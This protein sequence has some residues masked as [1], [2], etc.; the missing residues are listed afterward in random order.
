MPSPDEQLEAHLARERRERSLDPPDARPVHALSAQR[1]R[2]RSFLDEDRA[3]LA[4][5]SRK[6]CAGELWRSEMT[7]TYLEEGYSWR[8]HD[9]D[10][11]MPDGIACFDTNLI[12]TGDVDCE[13]YLDDESVLIVMGSLRCA[14]MYSVGGLCV[15][16]DVIVRGTMLHYYN[17]WAFECLGKVSA[18]AFVSEDKMTTFSR[19]RSVIEYYTHDHSLGDNAPD[20]MSWL[21]LDPEEGADEHVQALRNAYANGRD[22]LPPPAVPNRGDEAHH[23]DER[24]RARRASRLRSSD[25]EAFAKLS[26]DPVARVRAECALNA[27]CPELHWPS[28][29]RDPDPRVRAGLAY[30][31][32][33]VGQALPM[34]L[35]ALLARDADAH[36]RRAV[37]VLPALDPGPRA[38]PAR[39]SGRRGAQARQ[40]RAA[41]GRGRA[42]A[43]TR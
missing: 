33:A 23:D 36:V 41:D 27:A 29:A 20:A 10:L 13:V 18:R 15:L 17:D 9:G 5:G 1:Y 8:V 2:F 39:R 43:P 38:S 14:E 3:A 24:A 30:G 37:A 22:P 16:G 6:V 35:Q 19:E 31:R 42:D 26:A 28:L 12:V 34:E 40:C 32:Y 11:L 7:R 21:A 4:S 25:G